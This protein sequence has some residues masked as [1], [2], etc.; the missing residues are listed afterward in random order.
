MKNIINFYYQMNIENIHLTRGVYYFTYREDSYMFVPF[1]KNVQTLLNLY[2]LNQKLIQISPYYYQLILNKENLPYI[3]IDQKCYCLLKCS[4]VVQ[5]T[6]S[7]YDLPLEHVSI[8]RSIE[9]LIRFPWTHLWMQ[10]LDYLENILIHVEK[11]SQNILPIFFYYMGLAENAIQYVQMTVSNIKK[12]RQDVFVVCH[13]RIDVKNSV[14]SLYMPLDLVLDYPARDIAE[15]LKSL[16]FYNEYDISEVEEYLMSLDFGEFGYSL[17]YGRM[18]YPSFFFDLCD[19]V[20]SEKRDRKEIIRIG[21]R[22]EEYRI[23]LK[24]IYYII[25]KKV[26]LE[27]V[28][29]ILRD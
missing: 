15:Y 20:F 18:L 27:E 12:D 29:W 5:D 19:E 3:Y 16:F 7:F 8:D 1:Y 13:H 11:T 24:E 6:M 28:R 22:M 2:H 26:Y 25:R 21:E 14:A 9:P 17:L 23:F 10:R 4:R